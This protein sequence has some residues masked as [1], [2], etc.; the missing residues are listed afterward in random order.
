M[1]L[2][3]T[4]TDR[5]VITKDGS[6]QVRQVARQVNLG[7]V[8]LQQL[9]KEIADIT[10]LGRGDVESVL[11]HLSEIAIRYATMGYSVSLGDLGTLTPR[12]SA[13][14]IP[15]G[16]KYT[17]DNIRKVNVRYTPSLDMKERLRAV[18]FEK[19][20]PTKDAKCPDPSAHTEPKN[21]E[22]GKE[23]GGNEVD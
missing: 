20:D 14:A 2:K 23:T 6:R 12:L 7:K 17:A 22:P 16:D 8:T 21:P 11:T 15:T 9:A 4:V 5:K 19:W 3:Y 18:T 13:K 10:S 1:A